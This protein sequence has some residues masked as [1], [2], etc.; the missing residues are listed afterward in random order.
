MLLLITM[1]WIFRLCTATKRG[2]DETIRL[3][4]SAPSQCV[5]VAAA[6]I[7]R[8]TGMG[9][10]CQPDVCPQPDIRSGNLPSS[11][12]HHRGHLPLQLGS[13]DLDFV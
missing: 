11:G 5:A 13:R 4:D 10:A 9:R 12:N 7:T 6:P 2:V 8:M 1:M 3:L